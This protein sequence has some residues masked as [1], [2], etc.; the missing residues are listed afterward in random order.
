MM[1]QTVLVSFLAVA[2]LTA[3]GAE[4]TLTD[5]VKAGNRD[6]V[7]AILATP[8]GKAAVNTAE[9]D[10]TT[11][12]HWAVRAD[13]VDVAGPL[14]GAGANANAANRYG[15]TP[16]SLAAGNASGTMVKLLLDAGANPNATIRDGETIL[17]AASRT[18]S[19]E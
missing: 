10:G 1:K 6:A 11:P 19:P 9:A 8:A 17:M 7:R 12:L 18:G 14:I 4:L 5:A 16:L 13:D 15:V 2:S 3:G